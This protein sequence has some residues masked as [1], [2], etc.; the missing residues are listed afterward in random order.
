MKRWGKEGKKGETRMAVTKQE[1]SNRIS[2][3]SIDTYIRN[4]M[5]RLKVI[6]LD[7]EVYRIYT[8]DRAWTKLDWL[9]SS[10]LSSV[11]VE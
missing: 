5:E 7:D 9:T 8:T 3:H 6:A 2:D 10:D 4:V 11:F 1:C